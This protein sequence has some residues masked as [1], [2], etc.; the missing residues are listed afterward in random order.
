M[1]K[2][3]SNIRAVFHCRSKIA[4]VIG[5]CENLI[6]GAGWTT[7]SDA[8][9]FVLLIII[10]MVKPTGIFGEKNIDKV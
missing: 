3:G 5:V 2:K 4:F 6:K 1:S 10:L 7:F 9:T 8:F